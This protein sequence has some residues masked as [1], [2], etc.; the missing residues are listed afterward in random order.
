MH[1]IKG[2][3]AA[4]TLGSTLLGSNAQVTTACNPLNGKPDTQDQR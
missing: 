1:F 4:V 2:A 3:V